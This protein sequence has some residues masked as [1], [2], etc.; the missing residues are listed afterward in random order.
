MPNL[1]GEEHSQATMT[2]EDVN[3]IMDYLENSEVSYD[4]TAF[5]F[6]IS[7]AMISNINTGKNWFTDK[8][9]YPLRKSSPARK[10]AQNG[11]SLFS[12]EEVLSMR[13]L[14]ATNSIA[15]IQEKYKDR[16]SGS[17]IK[18]ILEGSSYKHV[19]VYKRSKKMWIEACID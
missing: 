9:K 19:P 12:D 14:Y 4:D 18:H 3:K 8:K 17:S 5:K 13:K 7:K 6:S 16:A 15:Q 1:K 2:Q 10:G 11:M